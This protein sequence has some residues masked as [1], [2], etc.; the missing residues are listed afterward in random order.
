MKF[1]IIIC[2]YNSENTLSRC[3][4]SIEAQTY[5]DY[6][7]V[8]IDDGSQD[9]SKE[10][11][12]KSNIS[13][14]IR[15]YYQKN[16]GIS[17]ARNNGIKKA[18]GKYLLFLD[19]DDTINCDLLKKLDEYLK[20]FDCDIVRYNANRIEKQNISSRKYFLK[21]FSPLRG[22]DAILHFISSKITYGPLWL[23]CYRRSFLEEIQI[24][25]KPGTIHEDFL[26][27]LWLAKAKSI[28]GIEYIGYNYYKHP[29]SITD[30]CRQ[31]I[32]ERRF[33]D[34][35]YYYDLVVERMVALYDKNADNKKAIVNSALAFLTNNLKYFSGSLRERMIQEIKQRETY[36][37]LQEK[38]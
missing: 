28:G 20:T 37:A 33:H 16:S 27:C 6:E 38:K 32:A 30:T 14:K 18:S 25:F 31:D 7:V 4:H 10:I 8:F 5:A 3:L 1:S 11:V 22:T 23:Y 15:Y 24:F 26:N 29:L 2:S 35:L 21:N 12:D 19:A 17:V 36:N 34:I 9:K 13:N